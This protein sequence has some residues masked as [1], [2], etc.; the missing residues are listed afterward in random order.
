MSNKIYKKIYLGQYSVQMSGRLGKILYTMYD[1][2]PQVTYGHDKPT[3]S[4][5][6]RP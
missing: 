2:I 1:H 3:H 6:C 5:L 4:A